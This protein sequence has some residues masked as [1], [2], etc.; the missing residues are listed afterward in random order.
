MTH[1]LR[2]PRSVK[3]TSWFT[4]LAALLVLGW[5]A[6]LHAQTAGSPDQGTITKVGTTAAQFIKLGVGARAI[7]MGGSF[8]AEASDL[9]ALYWNP[10][11]LGRLPGSAVQLSYTQYL[12][13]INYNYAAFGTNLGNAGTVALSLIFLDSGDM[14]V[15]TT[16]QPEGTG[17]EFSVQS[18]ALQGS[19]ARNL[20]DRFSIG[21]TVKYI[22][23]TVWHSSASAFA[24][25]IGTLFTTPF[26]RLKLGASMSNFGP[27]LQ[28]SGRDILFSQDPS[29][30]GG[31][32]EIVNA[33]YL[34][35]QYELPLIFRIGLAFDAVRT[36]DHRIL[37]STDA[38]HPNDNSQYLNLGAEYSFRDLIFLRGGYRDLFE[39]DGEERFTVGG[40]LNLRIDRSLRASVDYAYADF[41][42]L[43]STHWFTLNLA[44]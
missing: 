16:R 39:E 35:D 37:L 34:L 15:R 22:Q 30:D 14:Q 24:F 36:A 19:Y 9:S 11:G 6:P 21:T 10:A 5:T 4:L 43:E 44:F 13:D 38:A 17:E 42:R 3:A 2:A 25:D 1:T 32:V 23:E 12:A 20:T 31:T 33:Q 18:F 28:L 8:V 26:D 27:K 41:G 7:G 40:G 29:T